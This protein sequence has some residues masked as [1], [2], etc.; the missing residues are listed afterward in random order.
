MLL[1]LATCTIWQHCNNRGANMDHHVVSC[2]LETHNDNIR[3]GVLRVKPNNADNISRLIYLVL[4]VSLVDVGGTFFKEQI[5][6]RLK[7]VP[8]LSGHQIL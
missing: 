1:R 5:T 8:L 2:S 4:C 3:S 7:V 6:V